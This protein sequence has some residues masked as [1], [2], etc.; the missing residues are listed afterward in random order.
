MIL[1]SLVMT[2]HR[3]LPRLIKE[4]KES[5]SELVEG[6]TIVEVDEH[7]S[8]PMRFGWDEKVEEAKAVAKESSLKK[9]FS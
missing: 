8:R 6:L 5:V 3:T 2:R 7:T 4:R 1:N 9:K